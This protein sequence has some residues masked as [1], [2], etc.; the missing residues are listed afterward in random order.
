MAVCQEVGIRRASAPSL[1][2]A[3][4]DQGDNFHYE[5]V[6]FFNGP[7]DRWAAEI[8]DDLVDTHG[9]VGVQV[10]GDALGFAREQ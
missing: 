5:V 8:E 4:G 1:V 3:L 6:H 10:L 9:L 2:P 7:Q